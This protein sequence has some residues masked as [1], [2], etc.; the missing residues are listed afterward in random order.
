M[1]RA[2]MSRTVSGLAPRRAPLRVAIGLLAAGLGVA[3]P[4]AASD[5]GALDDRVPTVLFLG[6]GLELVPFAVGGAMVANSGDQTVRR[7]SVYVSSAGFTL[8]PLIAHGVMREWGRGAAFA[9]VPLACGVAL[10]IIMQQPNGD[11]LSEEGNIGTRVPFWTFASVAL[12]AS[13]V[14]V[15]DAA[16]A[17]AR[18]AGRAHGLYVVP[19]RV[20]SGA[21]MNLGGTF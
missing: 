20:P 13:A 4:A 7:A 10:A 9:A 3:R 14:G 21:A 6:G 2:I 15:I 11:V 1:H 17:P 8:A 5:E 19:S 18:A 16:L 12:A